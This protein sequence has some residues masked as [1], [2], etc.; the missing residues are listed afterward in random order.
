MT[1]RT[2]SRPAPGLRPTPQ[3]PLLGLTILLVEDSRCASEAVRLMALRSGARI[4]RADCLRSAHRHLAAYRPSVVIVDPGLPDGSGLDLLREV[5]FCA[6][7][8]PVR[9]ALSGD[10]G[11]R[12]AA[13]ASGAHDFTVKPLDSLAAFQDLVLSHLP[14]DAIPGGPRLVPEETIRPDPIAYRDDIAHL[15]ALLDPDAGPARLHYAAQFGEAAALAGRDMVMAQAARSLAEALDRAAPMSGPLVH[16]RDLAAAR[17]RDC[18]V[19]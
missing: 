7:P 10:P 13:L 2:V 15:S 8:I 18:A 12:A 9:L 1:D 17:S 16:L 19:V 6:D 11:G 4:R 3:R 5:A 14:P